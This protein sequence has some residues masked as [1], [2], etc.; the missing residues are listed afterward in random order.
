MLCS[1]V[2]SLLGVMAVDLYIEHRQIEGSTEIAESTIL[3]LRQIGEVSGDLDRYEGAAT[4]A[5]PDKPSALD[6]LRSSRE[7]LALRMRDFDEHVSTVDQSTWQGV[8]GR[9]NATPLEP[10]L[11]GAAVK[12]RVRSLRED[13]SSAATIASRSGI[14]GMIKAERLHTLHGALEALVLLLMGVVSLALLFKWRK[15]ET[16][17]RTRDAQV[18]EQLRRAL[19]DL[20]GFAGRLAHDLRAPLQP[21]LIGSQTIE[22]AAE[23][24]IVRTHAERIGRS[25][26][27][28]GRMCE[29]ILQYARL[30]QGSAQEGAPVLVN[31][32]IQEVVAEFDEKVRAGGARIVTDLGSDFALACPSEVV[33]SLVSNLVD[34]ALKYGKKEGASAQVVVRTRVEGS[35]GVIEVEDEGPGISPELR[36][37]VCEP[38]FRGQEG[39]EGVGLGLSIVQRLVESQRGR[40]EICAGEKGGALFRILLPTVSTS[41]SQPTG[42]AEARPPT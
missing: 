30:S 15:E 12:D 32:E 9:I 13:L 4:Y 19:V 10:E 3:T 5:A 38:L 39:G 7:R 25:A 20:E 8:R 33:H 35:H 41:A 36:Q 11:S 40:A 24:D 31:A 34:N 1:A 42:G 29:V 26:R 6:A 2:L 28:L 23:S 18:E 17:A 21:I 37:R 14:G 27:R 16:Q 22:R